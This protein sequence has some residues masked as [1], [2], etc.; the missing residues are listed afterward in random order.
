MIIPAAACRP[1]TELTRESGELAALLRRN[2]NAYVDCRA[3]RR[4][5]DRK[6]YKQRPLATWMTVK[7]T[8]RVYSEILKDMIRAPDPDDVDEIDVG[9]GVERVYLARGPP[10]GPANDYTDVTGPSS[11]DRARIDEDAAL[12]YMIK[13]PYDY[14]LLHNHPHGPPTASDAD[15]KALAWLSQLANWPAT[16]VIY[17]HTGPFRLA[18]HELASISHEHSRPRRRK[19][20][21]YKAVEWLSAFV[22]RKGLDE[23][24]ET[25][26]SPTAAVEDVLDATVRLHRD[27]RGAHRAFELTE[28]GT[29]RYTPLEIVG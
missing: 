14:V 3:G 23:L 1:P 18:A 16:A 9:L 26:V 28:D 24:V 6:T 7:I 25:T 8:N 21:A 4:A 29:W 13:R 15:T 11:F 10:A 5:V 22:D 19:R 17:G 27:C 12:Y 20:H 2:P